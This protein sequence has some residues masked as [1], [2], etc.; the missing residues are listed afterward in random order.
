MQPSKKAMMFKK[1]RT[2]NF[3]TREILE[4][5]ET[6]RENLLALS[7]DIWAGIDRQ[8]LDA[9][10]DG[11]QF[12]RTFVANNAA[13]DMAASDL[14]SLIQQ[15]MSVRLGEGEKT[16]RGDREQNERIITELN[17]EDPHSLNEDFTYKRPFGF[18]LDGEAATGVT[19]WQR[20]FELVCNN[21]IE[22]D[23]HLFRSLHQNPDFIS[24]RGNHTVT[25]EPSQLRKA[26][27]LRDN[28]YIECNLSAIA[29]GT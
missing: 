26:L 14:S 18:I 3:R 22:R 17:R 1:S 8:D 11:V 28:L 15:F 25:F 12:M 4:D 19:T 10:D 27:K 13:F 23:E 24:N 21:L 16:G 9:F 6:V 20:L 29:F 2:T 7:D 5:L